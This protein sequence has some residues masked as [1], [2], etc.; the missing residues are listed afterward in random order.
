MNS[1]SDF[2][3][4][5][6]VSEKTNA[7]ELERHDFWKNS[8]SLRYEH[9]RFYASLACDTFWPNNNQK[10]KK[11]C[12]VSNY[13]V[14][15]GFVCKWQLLAEGPVLPK[16]WCQ[17]T[18][19]LKHGLFSCVFSLLFFLGPCGTL[20][21]RCHKMTP[22]RYLK[23][24]GQFISWGCLVYNCL[25]SRNT[26]A[27]KMSIV[28]K[29]KEFAKVRKMLWKKKSHSLYITSI[30]GLWGESILWLRKSN[31]DWS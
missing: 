3:N 27:W 16:W 22:T 31:R 13:P 1:L 19:Q 25:N 26:F 30:W 9:F 17:S 29:R 2:S 14:C 11:Y 28:G 6:I 7:W 24:N 4:G 15:L 10:K 20:S 8:Y 12:A 5:T 21:G 23:Q 18:L